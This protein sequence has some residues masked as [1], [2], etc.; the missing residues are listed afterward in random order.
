MVFREIEFFW[1]E[2][3]YMYNLLIADDNLIYVKSIVNEILAN[4][5]FVK[6]IKI[7]TDGKEAYN[8]LKNEKIDLLILDLKMP[9]YSG[10]D[11]LK[12]LKNDKTISI[13]KIIVVSGDINTLSYNNLEKYNIVTCLYKGSS[14]SE[15]ADKITNILEEIEKSNK[16]EILNGRI[17]EELMKLNYNTKHSGTTYIRES[18]EFILTR[19]DCSLIDNL[20]KNVYPHIAKMHKKSVG[21]IKN[22]IVKA[23]NNM[24]FECNID[25]LL[26][27]FS[28]TDDMKPTPKIVISTILNKIKKWIHLFNTYIIYRNIGNKSKILILYIF[29]V[30]NFQTIFSIISDGAQLFILHFPKINWLYF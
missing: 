30:L 1:G 22:N 29:S 26:N 21:N 9:T 8:Y 19:E 11:L 13:P 16:L 10:I 25:Y 3:K 4:A 2:Y 23:T 27:Y 28:F 24:Y 20:E 12:K 18:I 17:Y 15:L 7:A 14:V 6:L 5:N